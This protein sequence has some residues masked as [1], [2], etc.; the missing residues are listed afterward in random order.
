[1]IL[2]FH[3]IMMILTCPFLVI[4]PELACSLPRVFLVYSWALISSES[5]LNFF[6][7]EWL[8]WNLKT[9]NVHCNI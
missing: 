4:N 2:S 3:N 8:L 9:F 6:L 7:Q 1:M 5:V